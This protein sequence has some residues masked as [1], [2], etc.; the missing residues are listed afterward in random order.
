MIAMPI[1]CSRCEDTRRVCEAHPDRPWEGP[2]ACPCG[3]AGMPCLACNSV[4][5][6]TEAACPACRKIHFINLKTG[7]L[8][9]EE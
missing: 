5:E 6:V 8:F 3:A 2:R 4:D 7:K 9:N 1:V